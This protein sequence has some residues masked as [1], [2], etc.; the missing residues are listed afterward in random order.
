MS[1]DPKIQ[2][3]LLISIEDLNDWIEPLGGHPQAV[4]PNLNRLAKRAAV[5]QNAFA[6]A[7]ACSSS[8]TSALF[9]QAPW[10]T[11]IYTNRQSWAMKYAEGGR[12]SIVGQ[13]RNA[14]WETIG[15]GKVFHTGPSGFDAADWA[16][17]HH[18]EVDRFPQISEAAK[19]GLVG[20]QGDF[21]PI[22]DTA[23]PMSDDRNL[24]HFKTW[25]NKGDTQKFWAFGIYR[26][27]LPFIVP[28]RFFD[29][30]AQPIQPPPGF[31]GKAFDPYDETEF[32]KLPQAARK[33]AQRQM[34]RNLH[35]TGEYD[36]FVHAYLASI[37]YADHLLG[38]LLDHLDD[39][40]LTDSTMIVF[41]SD[42]GLQFGEKL[43]FR[44]F[45][46][47]ERAL[48]IPLMIA[49]PHSR[50]SRISEPVSLLDLYPTLLSVIGGQPPHILDGQDLMP[51]I[52][53]VQGRGAVQSMWERYEMKPPHNSYMAATVRTEQYRLIRYDDGSLELY[54][55]E[56][57]P[58]EMRNLV[59][60]DIVS[61]GS[62]IEQICSELMQLLPQDT[63]KPLDA[64]DL[65][66]NLTTRLAREN[67][68]IFIG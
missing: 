24:A 66:E 46:L 45:T 67:G 17:Y 53:G 65:P 39:Q 50:A 47:W 9:G 38:E 44:K 4:T 62:N 25:L 6:A 33:I 7:P 30:I 64:R 2:N 5:F 42:H 58:F 8:R 21:G 37:A 22:P 16:E 68:K 20:W 48:R 31:H 19:Q 63:A 13:A 57:D 36:A 43:A 56:N 55:H 59:N 27:H 51:I 29:M 54:D 14:G 11:G 10:R 34:G 52:N 26:P 23:P 60:D 41:W 35:K 49:Q 32:N 61:E 18:T 28:Q 15:A 3:I 40:G 1:T 12:Q